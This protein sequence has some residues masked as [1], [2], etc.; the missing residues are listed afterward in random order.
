MNTY[1]VAGLPVTDEL[2]HHGILGQRWGVRRYQN[3]DGTLTAE[4]KKRYG[5]KVSSEEA[6]KNFLKEDKR[7]Q[8]DIAKNYSSVNDSLLKRA[9]K[10][11]NKDALR[12]VFYGVQESIQDADSSAKYSKEWNERYKEIKGKN[13]DVESILRS[14]EDKD[15]EKVFGDGTSDKSEKDFQ[16]ANYLDKAGIIAK[17]IIEYD[18]DIPVSFFDLEETDHGY[19]N[20]VVATRSGE[21]YRRKGHAQKCVNEGLKWVN[22]NKEHLMDIGIYTDVNW[23]AFKGNDASV[24]L[25]KKSGFKEIAPRRPNDE[26]YGYIKN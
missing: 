23:Q 13:G 12:D 4:G 26:W 16:I 10:R 2:Y 1:Y 3:P 14:L 15:F 19:L 7:T 25:A 24:N 6:F 18:G 8:Y 5:K 9:I 20:A 21:D 11:Q 17:R 22:D